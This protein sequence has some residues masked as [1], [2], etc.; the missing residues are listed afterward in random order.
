MENFE[1]EIENIIDL[2]EKGELPSVLSKSL[3]L[4]KECDDTLYESLV[5]VQMRYINLKKKEK[6]GVLSNQD[7]TIEFAAFLSVSLVEYTSELKKFLQK[8]PSLNWVNNTME[9]LRHGWTKLG[10]IQEDRVI[11]LQEFE[12]AIGLNQR[13]LSK[14]LVFHRVTLIKS[15]VG[16]R[17]YQAVL[18]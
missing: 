14:K 13:L 9:T 12:K 17:A 10:E 2:L 8:P 5:Q 16:K 7:Q 6:N 15:T 18:Q 11:R 3:L 1:K 4:A